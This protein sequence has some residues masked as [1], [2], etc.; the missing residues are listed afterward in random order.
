MIENVKNATE[1][2]GFR[3]HLFQPPSKPNHAATRRVYLFQSAVPSMSHCSVS[4]PGAVLTPSGER[5]IV[6]PG[7]PWLAPAGRCQMVCHGKIHQFQ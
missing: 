2:Q 4:F 3:H 1:S 5:L 6:S 7:G